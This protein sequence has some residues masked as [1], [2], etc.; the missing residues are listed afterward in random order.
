MTTG[1]LKTAKNKQIRKVDDQ[2]RRLFYSL[3]T[4]GSSRHPHTDI[5]KFP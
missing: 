4:S 1:N 3:H 5:R 2:N